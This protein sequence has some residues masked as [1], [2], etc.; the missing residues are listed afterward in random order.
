MGFKLT[1]NLDKQMDK[2]KKRY[3]REGEYM[4]NKGWKKALP[5]E[6]ILLSKGSFFRKKVCKGLPAS[7]V[8]A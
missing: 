8:R 5:K 7:P 3:D 4:L 1:L 6:H 2:K